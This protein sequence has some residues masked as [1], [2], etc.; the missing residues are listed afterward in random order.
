M[1]LARSIASEGFENE[2]RVKS[3]AKD[4]EIPIEREGFMPHHRVSWSSRLLENRMM[5]GR[6]VKK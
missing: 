2:Q 4:L 1:F 3:D 6:L 5:K